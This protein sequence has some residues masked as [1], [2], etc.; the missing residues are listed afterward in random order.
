MHTSLLSLS[1]IIHA[2]LAVLVK[3]AKYFEG[4]T[5]FEDRKVTF[6]AK[7][8][9]FEAL[10]LLIKFMDTGDLQ[11]TRDNAQSL[12]IAADYLQFEEALRKAVSFLYDDLSDAM[13]M[14]ME[15]IPK[16]VL[17][18]YM[19]IY[20]IVQRFE[21]RT[22]FEVV[23]VEV[24]T[25]KGAKLVVPVHLTFILAHHIKRIMSHWLFLELHSSLLRELLGSD[26]L[27]LSEEQVLRTITMWVNHNQ[28]GRLVHM[29][30][31]L[32]CVRIDETMTVSGILLC[33]LRSNI[34]GL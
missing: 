17:I 31:L 14:D 4:V 5:S 26:Y 23:K 3:H 8:V 25:E 1:R 11:A 30:D 7:I 34:K 21:V 15:S 6:D 13:K 18:A 27:C 32:F 20:G 24:R 10:K 29:M 22:N 19:R 16:H 2:N 9:S 33:E 12:I 28:K